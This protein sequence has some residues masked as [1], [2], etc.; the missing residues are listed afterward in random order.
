MIAGIPVEIWRNEAKGK[1]RTGATWEQPKS[2][3][4]SGEAPSSSAADVQW[5]VYRSVRFSPR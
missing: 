1:Y 5:N 2:M 4:M 3:S